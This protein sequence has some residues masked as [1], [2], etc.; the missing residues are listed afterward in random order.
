MCRPFITPSRGRE[1][2]ALFGG[3]GLHCIAKLGWLASRRNPYF[4]FPCEIKRFEK[5]ARW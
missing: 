5:R 2:R 1:A 4:F 3:G